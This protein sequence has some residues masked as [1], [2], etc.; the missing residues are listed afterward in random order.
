M[1]TILL[2][3]ALALTGLELGAQTPTNSLPATPPARPP[4]FGTTNGISRPSRYQPPATP[5]VFPPAAGQ[6]SAFGQPPAGQPSAFGQPAAGQPSATPG[7][8]PSSAAPFAKSVP[9][10]ETIPA[11]TINLKGVDVSQVLDVYAKL[12]NRT[13]L[14]ANLPAAKDHFEDA[15]AAD[16]DRG[17]PGVAGGARAQ[18]H[19]RGQHRR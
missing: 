19:F 3:L 4:R 16:Q 13:L 10:E 5:P 11:G 8:A 15:D 18:R 1:K 14:R 2:A 9:P 6:P 17:H 12:V 7:F